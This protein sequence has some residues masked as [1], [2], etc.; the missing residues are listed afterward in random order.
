MEVMVGRDDFGRFQAFPHPTQCEI[1]H[2]QEHMILQYLELKLPKGIDI[3]RTII[4]D[5]NC[6]IGITCGCYAK[7]HRQVA[8]IE[9]AMKA[10]L[11]PGPRKLTHEEEDER[12]L[13]ENS[14]K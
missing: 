4:K 14:G 3:P 8:H 12:D 7:F 9:D 10:R 11:K 2:G 1:C 6:L 13:R 5:T